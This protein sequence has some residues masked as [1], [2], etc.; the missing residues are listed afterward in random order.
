MWGGVWGG[1]RGRRGN[2]GLFMLIAMVV[3]AIGYL[4]GIII[5]MAISRTTRIRRRRRI[6]G[7]DP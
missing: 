5:R 7:A 3:G 2:F 4:L 6:G 1:G